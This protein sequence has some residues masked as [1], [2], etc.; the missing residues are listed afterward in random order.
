MTYV[1]ALALELAPA[2]SP[3]IGEDL[4][5][6]GDERWP[7]DLLA[8]TDADGAGGLVAVAGRDDPFGVRNDPAVVHE[9]VDVVLSGQQRADVSVEH[10]VGLPGPLDRLG[11]LGIG[12]M[13]EFPDLPADFLLPSWKCVDIGVDARV[14]GVGHRVTVAAAAGSRRRASTAPCVI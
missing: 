5:E 4:A 8:R 11:D 7:V 13:N 1:L 9:H 2:A 3:V 10:D 12:G 14:I 6:H